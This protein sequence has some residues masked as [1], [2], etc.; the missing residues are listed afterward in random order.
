MLFYLSHCATNYRQCCL[1]SCITS[2]ECVST[3][4]PQW[5]LLCPAVDSVVVLQ[6]GSEVATPHTPDWLESEEFEPI[7]SDP[8][9]MSAEKFP[10]TPPPGTLSRVGSR[11]IIFHSAHKLSKCHVCYYTVAIQTN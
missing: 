10:K 4:N 1:L 9:F 5:L 6:E 7:P 2:T 3:Y 11:F 8:I